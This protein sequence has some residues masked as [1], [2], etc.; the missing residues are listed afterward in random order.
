MKKIIRD[1][2]ESLVVMFLVI[3]LTITNL[4]SSLDYMLKDALYQIPR[5]VDNDIKIIAID[6]RTIEELGQINTWSRDYYAKLIEALNTYDEAKPAVIAF[7]II[8]SPK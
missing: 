2:L 8:F 7:D 6:E 4:F 3:F 1:V 5:G